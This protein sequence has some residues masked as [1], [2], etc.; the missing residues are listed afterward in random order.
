[1]ETALDSAARLMNPAATDPDWLDW[2]ASWLDLAFDPTWPVDHRR[3]LVIEGAALQ[4]G[5]GTPAALRR[6]LELYTGHPVAV[7]EAF[8]LRPQP[9]IELGARGALG[10]APLGPAIEDAERFA[11]RFSV[12]VTLPDGVDPAA[13]RVAVRAIVDAVKPTHSLY[14]LDIGSGAAPRIGM[15]TAVDGTVIPGAR[16]EPPPGCGDG[17]ALG[18]RRLGEGAMAPAGG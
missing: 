1:M 14:R 12:T 16:L 11:H 4:A 3:R 6:Y 13:A 8:R 9:P 7:T 17:P 15:G 18:R 10:V 2:I 5:R